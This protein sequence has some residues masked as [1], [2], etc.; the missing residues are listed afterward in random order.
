MDFP[1]SLHSSFCVAI[2][3]RMMRAWCE[4]LEVELSCKLLNDY[5]HYCWPL[6]MPVLSFCL[7]CVLVVEGRRN[8]SRNRESESEIARW[9]FCLCSQRL[10]AF[11]FQDLSGSGL[12]IRGSICCF[13]QYTTQLAWIILISGHHTDDHALSLNLSSSLSSSRTSPL[14]DLSTTIHPPL[15]IRPVC[16]YRFVHFSGGS[17]N[18]THHIFHIACHLSVD[19]S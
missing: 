1:H 6:Q 3:S 12:E 7:T 2:A 9:L 17:R 15:W 11:L 5:F 19:L 4:G 14:I 13:S 10:I 16:S 18:P 8:V